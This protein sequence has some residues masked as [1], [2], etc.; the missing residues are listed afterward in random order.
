MADIDRFR[1]E[2]RRSVDALYRRVFGHDAANASQLRWNWQYLQNPNNPSDGPQIWLAREGPTIIGQYAT[3]PVRLSLKGQDIHGSWGMDV[4]VAPER[5]RQGVGEVLF[6]T[7][8]QNVGASLGLGL[9]PSSHRLFK[10]M[11]WPEVGPVPCLVK[12]LTRRALRRP[13]WPMPLN[14]LIGAVTYPYIR[15]ISRTKPLHA[16]IEPIRHFDRRFTELWERVGPSFG[17]AVR[18]DA[19]YLNWK[20]VEPPHVRY[21]IVALKRD[22]TVGGYAVYRHLQEPRG[23]VTILVDFLVEPADHQGFETLV[24]WV[25]REARAANSDKI[26]V[27]DM[28]AGFRKLLRAAGYFHVKSTLEF[29]IKVNAVPAPAGFYEH[30]GDWHFTLGD[31]DQD[32]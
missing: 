25:D 6:R 29:T 10:K 21:S 27:F 23:R 16:Q 31:S 9:S 11:K 15:V 19:P 1:L 24:R 28:H 22:E 32:R 5:Q 13:T 26:R 17:L 18:R 12:P 2:D 8:D 3:M 4:M 30:T 7:W 14:R 20:Y